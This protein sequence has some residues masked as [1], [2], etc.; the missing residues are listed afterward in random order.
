MVLLISTLKGIRQLSVDK[1]ID[2]TF[3]VVSDSGSMP[4]HIPLESVVKVKR[5]NFYNNLIIPLDNLNLCFTEE[6]PPDNRD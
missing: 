5:G 3:N 6:N 4:S 1:K 2:F